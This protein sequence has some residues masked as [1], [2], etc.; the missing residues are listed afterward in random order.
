MKGIAAFLIFLFIIPIGHILTGI[1]IKFPAVGQMTVIILC[2][3]IAVAI[4]YVTKYLSSEVWETFWGLIAGVLLWA[5][6][7]EMGFRLLIK[8]F[9]I[10]ET[11]AIELTVVLIAPLVLYLFFNENIRC[12]LVIKTV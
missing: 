7:F 4:M 2:L 1:A 12:S 6:L 9:M 11:K 5:S 10:D 3:T 8:T